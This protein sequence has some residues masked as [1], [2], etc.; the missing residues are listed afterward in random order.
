MLTELFIVVDL[1][2]DTTGGVDA[3]L[4]IVFLEPALDNGATRKVR[5]AERELQ[6]GYTTYTLAFEGQIYGAL[7][8]KQ[9]GKH[10]KIILQRR[11]TKPIYRPAF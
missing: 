6:R 7:R 8:R 3:G 4:P 10:S 11:I 1:V 2:V 9:Q 5:L